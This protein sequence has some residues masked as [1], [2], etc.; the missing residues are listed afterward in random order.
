MILLLLACG[1]EPTAPMRLQSLPQDGAAATLKRCADEPFEE[2]AT[3]C[4]VEAAARAG[5]EGDVAL[6][7]TACTAQTTSDWR[8]E[9]YFRAGEELGR[10]THLQDALRFC[11]Q[12]GRFARFCTTHVGWQL[13]P[14]TPGTAGEW[15]G[16]AEQLL[17][18]ELKEEGSD[19][20]RARWWFNHYYGTGNLD[21]AAAKAAPAPEAPHAWG[22]W[23]LEAV[24]LT[25]SAAAA[26]DAW[27]A[28]TILTGPA[29]PPAERVG[30][31]DVP[32]LIEGE[33]ELPHVRTFG[34]SRRLV[35]ETPEED[36]DIALIEALYFAATTPGEAFAPFLDDP[37]PRVRYAAM[38]VWRILPSAGI[39]ARLQTLA[40]D[41]DPVIRAHA[42]D[43]LQYRTWE[44]KGKGGAI[45]PQPPG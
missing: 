44:G 30:R 23:A 3:I 20:L 11:A 13:P 39:E 1:G 32:I 31:Y 6:A 42:A 40:A 12:A 9:C 15:A 29:L 5:R 8:E 21:P 10:T 41:P 37:R 18:K 17:P 25:G 26:R 43:A 28:G 38:H 2:L 22:A 16:F 34:G 7:T 4:R 35:G 45:P 27:A 14:E 36:L 33:A 24:R 19:I